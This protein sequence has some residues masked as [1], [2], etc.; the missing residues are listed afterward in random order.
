MNEIMIEFLLEL[1]TE[2]DKVNVPF[3][4]GGGMGLYLRRQYG[5][6][7][8]QPR[9]PFPLEMRATQDLD[10]F[11]TSEVIVAADKMEALKATLEKL[12]YKPS[13]DAKYF[14]FL[15][16]VV[17]GGSEQNLKIDFLAAPPREADLKKVK[18]KPPRIRSRDVEGLHAFLTDEAAGIDFDSCSI[19][20]VKDGVSHIVSIPSAFNYLVLKLYAFNDRKDREDPK[21]DRGRHHAFDIFTT[22]CSMGE[23]DWDTAKRHYDRDKDATYLKKAIGICNADFSSPTS[24]GVLRLRENDGYRKWAGAYEPYLGTFLE[25]LRELF[26]R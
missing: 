23:Q 9:Y 11:L 17:I 5:A 1:K 18:I 4:L 19:T 21:S 22:V 15:K 25:D 20:L 14:Q 13:D 16:K 10:V 24:A 26:T 2:L 3:I 7:S 8:Q 12:K 6:N